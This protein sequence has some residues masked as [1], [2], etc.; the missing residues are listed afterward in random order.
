M[1]LKTSGLRHLP[2]IACLFH[3]A[4]LR[5]GLLRFAEGTFQA[6]PATPSLGAGGPGGTA[7]PRPAA[8]LTRSHGAWPPV[9]GFTRAAQPF[10]LTL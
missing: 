4:C 1:G 6:S 2:Q 10:A 3:G 7:R 8:G 9:T 5:V